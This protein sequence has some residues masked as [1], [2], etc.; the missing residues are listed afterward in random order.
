MRDEIRHV[1]RTL[2]ALVNQ[3]TVSASPSVAITQRGHAANDFSSTPRTDPTRLSV[4]TVAGREENTQMAMTRE[5]SAEPDQVSSGDVAVDEPMST[6]YAVTRLRNIR[7]NP[8]NTI[9]PPQNGGTELSDI[10][11][12]GIITESEAQELYIT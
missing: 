4:N 11:S 7:S 6:L 2:D 8:A 12:R 5:N 10:I 9:R 1:R 3:T